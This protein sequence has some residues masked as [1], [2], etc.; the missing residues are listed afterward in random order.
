[1]SYSELSVWNPWWKKIEEIETDPRI[2]DWKESSFKWQPRLGETF[3]D[4]DIIYVLRGPR[5]VGK[6]TLLKLKIKNLLQQGVPP[7]NIFYYPCDALDSPRQLVSVIDFYLT[8]IKKSN[9]RAYLMIDEVAMLKDWQRGIKLLI[10]AGKVENCTCILT[11]SHSI[12]LRKASESLSGR[13]GDVYKLR[14]GT[15]DKILLPAKFSEYVETREKNLRQTFREL[16]LLPIH[17]RKELLLK[18][19]MGNIPIEI[20]RLMFYS[21]ELEILLD[22][23]L[24]TG[25]IP[26]AA[27]EYISTRK[28]SE[29][30][31][32]TFVSFLIRD[33]SRWG[34]NENYARQIVRRI[35]ETLCSRVSWNSLK[36]NTEVSDHKTVE[37]YVNILKDSFIVS[38]IYQLNIDKDSP[39]YQKEKKIYF[40][41]PFIF[42]ACRSWVYGRKAFESS[43]EFLESAEN[44]SKLV[45]CIVCNHIIR[46]MFNLFP[47]SLFDPSNYIFYWRGK[48]RE[49]DFAFKLDEKYISIE[50]KYSSKIQ[51][52]DAFGIYDFIKTGRAYQFG[53]IISKDTLKVDSEYI[54]VP[55]YLFLL[56]A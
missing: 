45:E 2:K 46:F 43:L 10:D 17:R 1:M 34:A 47:S 20:E 55:A 32:E 54:E 31:Y 25:G 38:Y 41:D 12:D 18:L 8:R 16:W 26:Q 40:Q 3:E 4:K 37:S 15:P 53:L 36:E 48:K 24:V 52:R 23:Y 39:F 5:R 9:G 6:T 13:R 49:L 21:N 28:I 7:E 42:H 29:N 44:K 27:N 51:K 56:L 50:V 33:I 30:T 19:A 14:Y 22:E 11:G 35:I